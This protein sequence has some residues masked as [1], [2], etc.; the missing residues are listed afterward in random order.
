MYSIWR[1]CQ[2]RV[3]VVRRGDA[4]GKPHQNYLGVFSFTFLDFQR[5]AAALEAISLLRLGL[6]WVA[7]ARPRATAVKAK[8]CKES[9][10]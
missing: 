2:P 7:L 1:L 8:S 5:A 4:A 6:S 9:P 3:L 10:I